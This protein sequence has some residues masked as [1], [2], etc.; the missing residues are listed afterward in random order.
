MGVALASTATARILARTSEVDRGYTTPCHVSTLGVNS[1]GYARVSVGGTMVYA[2]KW[3]WVE[4]NGLVPEGRELDHLCRV[5]NCV[6]A[7]HLEPVTHAENT[8][9]SITS[10]QTHCKRKHE[11]TEENVARYPSAPNMRV[12][13]LC[14]VVRREEKRAA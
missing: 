4:Q 8:R 10:T 11:L 14:V 3:V 2:H 12:C 7:S 1:E 13:K 9:R 6:R 5:R